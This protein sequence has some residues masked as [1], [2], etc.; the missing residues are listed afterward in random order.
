MAEEL[1]L[2]L[3]ENEN[4]NNRA[5]ERIK[6]LS[7]KVR[8][9][10]KERDEAQAVAEAARA[11]AE[12]ATKERDFFKDFSTLASKYPNATEFQDKIMDKVRNGYSPEDATVSVLNAEGKLSAQPVEVA[13]IVGPAAGGSASTVIP[14]GDRSVNEMSRDEKRAALEAASASGELGDVI[15]QWRG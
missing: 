14:N 7:S 11:E 5:E 9:T 13:P 3:S 12:T 2:D 1:E 8:N 15:R 4:I 10:A 6:D